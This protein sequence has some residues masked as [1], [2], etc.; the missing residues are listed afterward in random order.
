ML[1]SMGFRTTIAPRLS[2]EDGIEAVRRMIPQTWIDADKC[3][4]GLRAIREYR[5]KVDPKRKVSFGPLH[6][7]TSHGAD[8]LRYLMTAYEVPRE[9]KSARAVMNHQGSWLA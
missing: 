8:A 5:E 3:A 4:A 2:V 7:W 9:R 1:E 6:D